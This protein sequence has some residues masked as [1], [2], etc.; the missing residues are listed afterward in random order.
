M[1]RGLEIC[2]REVKPS[3]HD[4]SAG[5]IRRAQAL[6]RARILA[7]VPADS[8][9][10]ALDERGKALTTAQFARQLESWMRGGRDVSF[11]IGGA[12][13]LDS[14][15]KRDAELMLSLSPMTLP[16]ALVR[17]VIAEQLYR[18]A[19]LIRNHPYHRE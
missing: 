13:G 8:V 7:A 12:D 6:E 18:A 10:V 17:V 15:L 2:L 4:D 19:S 14:E 9:K 11:L 3:R 1:P 5:A 16:H